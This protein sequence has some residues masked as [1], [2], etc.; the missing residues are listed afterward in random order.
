MTTSKLKV[1]QVGVG[2]FGAARRHYMRE[3]GLF[4]LVSIYDHNPDF[5]A[6]AHAEDGAK[7]CGSFEELLDTP[8]LEAL[9]VSTG[10]KYHAEQGLAATSGRKVEPEIRDLFVRRL[11]IEP[12]VARADLVL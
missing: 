12:N 4:D 6:Q 2:N 3:T 9:I 5:L 8:G 7:I 11:R 10:G 1:A